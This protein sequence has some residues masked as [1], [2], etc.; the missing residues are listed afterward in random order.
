MKITGYKSLKTSHV[1]G[2]PIGD[3]NGVINPG[4]TEVPILL[5]TTDEGVTGIG[6]GD[7]S[8]IDRVFSAIEGQDP[9]AVSTLYDRMLAYVFKAG[10]AGHT[11]GTIGTIDMALWDLK[12]K[13]NDEPLWRT[14]GGADPFVPGYA[15]GLCYGLEDDELAALYERFAE[16]G[17]S[18]AKL[19]GGID[20]DRD[21]R[22]LKLVRDI[23]KRNSPRPAMMFDANE[24]WSR[25]QAIRN[26]TEIEKHLDLTWIEEPVRRWDA[27]G[28]AF[29]SRA[30][31]AAV[32]T[33][34]NLT[35]LEQYLPLL[36]AGA[37]DVVQ[38]GN[39]WGITHFMRTAMAAHAHNLPVSPVGNSANA[40]AHAATAIP[41]MMTIEVQDLGF[42]VG[43]R[44]DQRFEDG[45][46]W[47]GEAPGLGVSYDESLFISP[48]P[49]AGDA[50][51]AGPHVR[52][53]RAGLRLVSG[54]GPTSM[55]LRTPA[56]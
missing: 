18:S 2:R 54:D 11:F 42:P 21:I 8:E 43:L 41:N 45:G 32:A 12:A 24:A 3:V 46:V 14:L 31:K 1:W 35:G 5:L 37:V 33:G 49:L 4:V 22:R 44:V 6:I 16:R 51:A 17:F 9:R 56:S 27:E 47:L 48:V 20:I 40:L 55:A 50:L 25:K 52:P 7:H 30:V 26:I 53:A 23:L 15:S 36:S 39:V 19:K 28:L 34:E 13:L 38:A 10:H 29:V